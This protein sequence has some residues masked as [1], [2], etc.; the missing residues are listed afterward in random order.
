MTQY[1]EFGQIPFKYINGLVPR[2]SV[3]LPL[4]RIRVSSGSMIDES[5][6]FQMMAEEDMSC[7]IDKNGAGGLDVGTIQSSTVYGLYFITDSRKIYAPSLI[8]SLNYGAAI[9]PPWMPY[10]YDCYGFIG[11]V[12]INTLGQ[13]EKGFWLGDDAYNRGFIYYTPIKV[14]NSGADTIYTRVDCSSA[15]P[16]FGQPK[17]NL[18]IDFNANAPGDIVNLKYPRSSSAQAVITACVDGTIAHTTCSQSILARGVEIDY[19][20]TGGSVD[21]YVTGYDLF[22]TRS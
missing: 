6:S 12:T 13:I 17:V 22:L 9:N 11:C 3:D 1:K 20:V 5:L 7:D 19:Q 10:G 14:L 4:T 18:N 21:L 2:L 15:I 8:L 16:F